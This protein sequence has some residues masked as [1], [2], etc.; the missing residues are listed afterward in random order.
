MITIIKRISIFTIAIV[1]AF[2][3]VQGQVDKGF[4]YQAVARDN[5]G[6]IMGSSDITV[7]L[8]ILN[9]GGTSL[10][11][12]THD[13]TTSPQGLFNIALGTEPGKVTLN[14]VENLQAINWNDGPYTIR[15]QADAGAGLVELGS[16]IIQAVPM[17][18]YGEDADADPANEM[19]NLSF[20][21]GNLSIS[22]GNS[23]VIPD[24][25]N[26]AD[27]STTNEIQNLVLNSG[28]LT[29]TSGSSD[30]DL[31]AF[32]SSEMAWQKSAANVILPTGSVG[33][34]T[35]A[36]E[37]VMDIQGSLADDELPIFQ[38][39]NDA[40][41]PVFAVYNE[42]VRVYIPDDLPLTKGAKGGFAVGGYNAAKAL[43]SDEYFLQVMPGASKL[44]FFADESSKSADDDSKGIKGGFAVGGYNAAKTVES[45]FLYMDPYA[46]P[47]TYDG[48]TFIILPIFSALA[49]KGN[50]YVG[51][52]AGQNHEGHFNTSVG[53]Q[54]G[55]E[56][57]ATVTF[58]PFY[59]TNTA[60]YNTNLGAYSGFTNI[61]GD[62]NVNLGYQAGYNN[63][64]SGNVLIGYQ[65]GSAETAA[66]DKLYISNSDRTDPLIKGDFTTEELWINGELQINDKV[67]INRNPSFALDISTISGE[68]LGFRVLGNAYVTGT[69]T[70]ATFS[71]SDARIKENI[72]P[73]KYALDII[74]QIR[75]VKFNFKKDAHPEYELPTDRQVGVIAQEVEAVIPELVI[76]DYT[77]IKSVA[78]DKLTAVLIEA[79]KE[80]QQMIEE[81]QVTIEE[82]S[83]KVEELEQKK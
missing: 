55:Y 38:V 59:Y 4:N 47:I 60:A 51:T 25:V 16:N 40:G 63:S 28:T 66:N 13:L 70:A 6:A 23:V 1:F 31:S 7:I 3:L 37:G 20:S 32:V 33:V 44:S 76:E 10:W 39:K 81:M 68:S 72:E 64:G 43:L 82:L 67:G 58:S 75:G 5:T 41:I 12:E 36:P 50:C 17:A 49:E 14:T 83:E 53:Y 42:G 22:N 35:S 79:V 52:M 48:G 78:Y 73:I 27:A 19:Q 57:D 71:N 45:S 46:V 69:M 18:L 65:A 24:L 61:V 15:V 8:S 9:E 62:K 11:E 77:G 2:P 74:S 56:A 80:Q 30:I 26:D 21:G 29:I 34:G 54:S